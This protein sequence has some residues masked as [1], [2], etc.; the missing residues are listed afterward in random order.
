MVFV[1]QVKRK[2]ERMD[3]GRINENTTDKLFWVDLPQLMQ[4]LSPLYNPLF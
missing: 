2:E 4:K 3:A 1:V